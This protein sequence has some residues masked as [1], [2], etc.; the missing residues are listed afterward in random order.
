MKITILNGNQEAD[1]QG[2]L[3]SQVKDK[4][5]NQGYQIVE[6]SLKEMKIKPCMG[7]F[8]CWI[9]D[10][11]KCIIKDD[12]DAICRDF[13]S[14]DFVI[15]ASPLVMGFP[16]SLLKNAMDRIIPLI[17]PYLEEVD[18][19]IHHKKRYNSYPSIGMIL[20]REEDTDEEDIKIVSDI[21]SRAAINLRSELKFIIFDNNSLEEV[22][23]AINNN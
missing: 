6:F 9:K 10:P 11:G 8:H 13:I 1:E 15:L 18:G 16:S 19:E 17:H 7:C 2:S 12:S 22:V 4:L 23:N 5:G 20:S 14:S 21:Y 3:L